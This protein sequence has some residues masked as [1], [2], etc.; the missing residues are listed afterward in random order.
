MASVGVLVEALD[1]NARAF[2]LHHEFAPLRDHPD[3]L[4]FHMVEIEKAFKEP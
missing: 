3:R 2:Y 4:F 1:A